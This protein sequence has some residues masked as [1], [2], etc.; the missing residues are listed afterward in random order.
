ML[1]WSQRNRV[2][3]GMRGLYQGG[4]KGAGSRKHGE[5]KEKGTQTSD[6]WQHW[7]RGAVTQG[8]VMRVFHWFIWMPL[9]HIQGQKE[10]L[11][12]QL[13]SSYR[14]TWSPG[15]GA[16]IPLVGM[17][18]QQG[19]M[20]S[21]TCTKG[22]EAKR[23]WMTY[24]MCSVLSVFDLCQ[25]GGSEDSSETRA[26]GVI[27]VSSRDVS[28]CYHNGGRDTI[29]IIPNRPGGLEE[30][31]VS[32]WIPNVGGWVFENGQP[33]G[34]WDRGSPENICNRFLAARSQSAL[35][36]MVSAKVIFPVSP[37]ANLWWYLLRPPKQRIT[38]IFK[39]LWSMDDIQKA[40][41][42]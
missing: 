17:L 33:S 41:Y 26:W 29:D 19:N 8:K 5:P 11:W 31:Q 7:G 25:G 3:K 34:G 40:V 37:S 2:T 13:E 42:I 10:D 14:C 12:Q 28:S 6:K 32:Q 15:W 23:T 30:N 39:L 4:C 1:L 35:L 16:H 36:G 21:K 27:T 9:D 24:E 22:S 18:T 38:F 20:T